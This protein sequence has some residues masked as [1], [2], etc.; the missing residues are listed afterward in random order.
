MSIIHPDK[1]SR[2][3]EP[4]RNPWFVVGSRV[5]FLP[6]WLNLNLLGPDLRDL[7]LF[8]A[9]PPPQ[10]RVSLPRV[11]QLSLPPSAQSRSRRP[12]W[13]PLDTRREA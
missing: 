9:V 2:Y 5:V 3:I 4:D 6:Q 11:G 7:D 13:R 1:D 10:T 12:D 8:R